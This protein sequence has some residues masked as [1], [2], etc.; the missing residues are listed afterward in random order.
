[1]EA[2]DR[3]L[4]KLQ[5]VLS[6]LDP[7][8]PQRKGLA[9][10]IAVLQARG[11]ADAKLLGQLNQLFTGA[12][13]LT[14]EIKAS[15]D[16]MNAAVQNTGVAA[17][18]IGQVVQATIPDMNGAMSSLSAAAGGFSASLDGQKVLIEETVQLLD[19]LNVQFEQARTTGM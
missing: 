9:E 1:V 17:G 14:D 13:Q 4:A 15:A 7:E 11:E 12:T 18:S 10:K 16:S 19:G 3:A 5:E 6:S 2:N 8:D